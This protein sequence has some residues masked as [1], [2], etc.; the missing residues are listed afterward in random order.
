MKGTGTYSL[1]PKST[2]PIHHLEE[3]LILFTPKPTQARDLKVRPEMAH[4]VFL[5]L[6]SFGV[7]I[8][9]G[10]A[11]GVATEYFFGEGTLVVGV[12]FG[13]FFGLF[14]LWLDEHFPETLGSE[15]VDS[16]VR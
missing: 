8:W 10:S 6:H 15:V 11:R 1:H 9:E 16:L 13:D 2:T 3:I 14:G 7:D 12:V 5:A 4:V